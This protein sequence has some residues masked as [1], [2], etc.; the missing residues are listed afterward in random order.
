MQS[1]AGGTQLSPYSAPNAWAEPAA[2]QEAQSSLS[3]GRFVDAIKRYKWA[4]LAVLAVGTAAGFVAQRFVQP[5][6]EVRAT[7]W[8]SSETPLEDRSGPIRSRELLNSA[9]WVELLRSYRVADAVVRKHALFVKPAKLSDSAAFTD[10][11]LSQRFAPGKYRLEMDPRAGSYNLL[12]NDLLAEQGR[13]GD[14][15]GRKVGFQWAPSL[16]ALRPASGRAIEFT[17]STPRE[18]SIELI[19]RLGYRLPDRSNFLWLTLEDQDPRKAAAILNTWINEYVAVAGEL[20][21]K[22]ISEFANILSGQLQFAQQSLQD[23]EGS[24]QSFRV[25]AITQPSENAPVAAGLESTQNPAISA[26]FGMRIEEDNVRHD[27]EA[28]EALIAKANGQTEPLEGALLIPSVAQGAQGESLRQL[29]N[30]L[31]KQ[32]ADLNAARQMFTDEFKTVKDAAE[33]VRR[34]E[35]ELIPQ[36]LQL[37]VQQLRDREQRATQRIRTQS[38]D[39]QQIPERTIEEMRLRRRVEVAA[40]L[41]TTLQ[42]RTAEAKLAAESTQPDVSILDSAVAPLSPSA[43]T[44]AR[45]MGGAVLAS[46]GAALALAFLLD[47]LDRRVRY[48]EHASRDLGLAI[49][50]TVP[51]LPKQR[52]LQASP[53]SVAQVVEA[54]RSIRLNLSHSTAAADGPVAVAVTSSGPGEGK[55]LVCANLALSFADAGFRT[56]LVDGDTRRGALHSAFGVPMN[57]GLTDYLI[58]E[59][60]IDEVVH[61]TAHDRLVL[62]PRG[63]RRRRS[64]ELLTAPSMIQLVRELRSNADI[65]ILDTPPLAAGIDAFAIG[66]AATNLLMVLRVGKTDRRLAQAK[67]ELCDRLPIRLVGA[68]LNDAELK[69]EFQYYSYLEGYYTDEEDGRRPERLMAET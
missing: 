44:S 13:L 34:L 23:A 65:V 46:I 66:A 15:I 42:T 47:R 41:F 33:R 61:K 20:K 51:T 9:A 16:R 35:T 49:I 30:E 8:I 45:L 28:L 1:A 38:R 12:M 43:D 2:P 62:V 63:T 3:V 6:Y 18:T 53:E 57:R 55:S 31:N 67:L 54:F 64:P 10:F 19:N 48:P 7:I 60:A 69:G 24:L 58:G 17:V 36:K 56:V 37:V 5:K 14:S 32:R 27:R 40:A 29:F 21:R 11:A 68:V 50:G 59:A 25:T 22:N 26:Y 4:L 39:L 52:H